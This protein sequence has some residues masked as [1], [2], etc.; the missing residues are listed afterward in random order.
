[1]RDIRTAQ[2]APRQRGP[3]TRPMMKAAYGSTTDAPEGGGGG[4]ERRRLFCLKGMPK[5]AFPQSA[6][7]HTL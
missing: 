1:M 3:A 4:C 6:D 2:A 5:P 7:A